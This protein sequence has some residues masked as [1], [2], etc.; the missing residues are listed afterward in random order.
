MATFLDDVIVFDSDPF[1][2]RSRPHHFGTVQTVAETQPQ[3]S[4]SK[5]KISTTDAGFL[6][7]TISPAGVRPNTSK[8]TALTKMPMPSDLKQ[9]RSLLGGVS[10]YRNF[11]A[12]MAKIIRPITSLLK[13]GVKFVLTTPMETIVR[14]LL[15]ELP[16]PPVLVY[17]DW[18]AVADNSRPFLLYCDASIDGYGA[19]LQQEQKDGSIRPIVLS[20]R[21]THESEHHWTPLDL[22]AGSIVW[23]IK[24]LRGYLWGTPLRIFSDHE[25][26]ES[27]AKLLSK[28]PE[29][30]DGSTSS[31][32][33]TIL[34]STA[35]AAPT[36]TH[37]FCL[38][39]RC[40]R[41]RM[42]AAAKAA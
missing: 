31:R 13:Q 7:H 2:L 29:S 9:L 24:R 3:L 16:A 10:Y 27:L 37:I 30:N 1:A 23:S 8:F 42:T 12:D 38:G 26:L 33:T 20:S 11:M 15:E 22:E 35:K 14:T 4:P 28:P 18:D 40:P 5:A 25:A 36:V 19:T 39:Y 41:R 34:L 6:G 32:H 17:P 21:A